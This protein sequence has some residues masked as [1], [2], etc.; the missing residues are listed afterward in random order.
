MNTDLEEHGGSHR[1]RR[2]GLLGKPQSYRKVYGVSHEARGSFGR[3]G[4][5]GE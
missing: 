3:R 4:G 1:A 2:Q 5:G